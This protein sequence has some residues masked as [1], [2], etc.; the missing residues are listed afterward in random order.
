M[1]EMNNHNLE[2]NEVVAEPQEQ[3][4]A[5]KP[6]SKKTIIIGIIVGVLVAI[7]ILSLAAFALA[8][9]LID[10]ISPMFDTSDEYSFY[11]LDAWKDLTNYSYNRLID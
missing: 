8:P 3:M 1:E 7:I 9:T 4:T 11:D 6:K 10:V 2:N 5:P